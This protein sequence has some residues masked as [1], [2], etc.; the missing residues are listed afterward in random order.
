MVS[1]MIDGKNMEGAKNYCGGNAPFGKIMNYLLH[2][3]NQY[4]HSNMEVYRLS[5]H[6]KTMFANVFS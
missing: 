3:N 5:V 6:K 1:L 2:D 4:N